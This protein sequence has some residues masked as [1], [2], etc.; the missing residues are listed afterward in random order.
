[1]PFAHFA[2]KWRE[3]HRRLIESM[4]DFYA[5]DDVGQLIST[6]GIAESCGTVTAY[7]H[8][9]F[10]TKHFRYRYSNT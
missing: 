7:R 3:G 10:N 5:F 8:I 6:Q 2:W 9:H 4:G 1:M